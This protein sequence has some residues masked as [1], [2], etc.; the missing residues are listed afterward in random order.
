MRK[1]RNEEMKENAMIVELQ[2]NALLTS[3]ANRLS[4]YQKENTMTVEHR[5]KE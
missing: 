3:R 4:A 1:R 2:M 5:I